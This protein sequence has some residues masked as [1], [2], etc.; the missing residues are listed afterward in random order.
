MSSI[1]F[2]YIGA[3]IFMLRFV[4]NTRLTGACARTLSTKPISAPHSRERQ[5]FPSVR[6]PRPLAAE[7]LVYPLRLALIVEDPVTE[8]LSKNAY[9]NLTCCSEG[10][11][12]GSAAAV[13]H[14]SQTGI[15]LKIL[16]KKT[17]LIYSRDGDY[18]ID[19]SGG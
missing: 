4:L 19:L 2:P 1:I 9:P 7:W 5:W 12:I 15:S 6:A 18:K 13:G 16:F 8:F 10:K 3:W 17:V 14:R 11:K